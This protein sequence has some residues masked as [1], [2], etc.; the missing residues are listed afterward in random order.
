MDVVDWRV[1]STQTKGL[2][3]KNHGLYFKVIKS[4]GITQSDII[5]YT[6]CE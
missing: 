6:V 4:I 2:H 5:L 1:D 3:M